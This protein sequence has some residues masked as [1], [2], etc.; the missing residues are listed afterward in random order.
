MRRW[1]G[2]VLLAV[3]AAGLF[4]CSASGPRFSEMAG[5]MPSLGENEGRIYF[6]RNSIVGMA[7]QPDVSVNGQVVGTSRPS[8]F[9]YIDRPAGTYR[10]SARTEA[11]G[12]ID[13]V[14]RPKQ[15]AYVSMSISMGLLVGHPNF[16]RVSE[17]EGRKELQSLAFDDVF[18]SVRT[19]K[20]S[21]DAPP[22]GAAAVS[23]APAVVSK[24][25]APAAAVATTPLVP[26]Q[27]PTATA[28]AAPT[29]SARATASAAPEATPFAKTSL[30]DLRLL[31]QANR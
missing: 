1:I 24:P 20:A 6:Y 31:L 15:T 12:T 4:G 27:P 14:L 22:A 28:A 21:A 30:N 18:A 3:L 29:P 25:V 16:E 8:S 11:E 5:S 19:V 7:V 13:V 9:F 26:A 2:G 10:A 23:T 17:A